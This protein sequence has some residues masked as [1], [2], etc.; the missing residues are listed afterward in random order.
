MI[1]QY[2]GKINIAQIDIYNN[3]LSSLSNITKIIKDNKNYK[4]DN[5]VRTVYYSQKKDNKY[6]YTEDYNFIENFEYKDLTLCIANYT[7]TE[8]DVLSFPNLNIY[9]YTEQINEKIYYCD[10]FN[11]IIENKKIF[12]EFNKYDNDTLNKIYDLFI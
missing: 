11:I 6:I 5:F 4:E 3:K 7:Q 9:D 10:N 2:F 12:I 1:L 8:Q